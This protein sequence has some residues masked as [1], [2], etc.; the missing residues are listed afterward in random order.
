M[1]GVDDGISEIINDTAW[2][3]SHGELLARAAIWLTVSRREST[4]K[5]YRFV[6]ARPENSQK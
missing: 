3:A 6:S 4:E 5:N 1:H 2:Q